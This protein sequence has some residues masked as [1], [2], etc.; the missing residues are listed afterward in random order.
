MV[1]VGGMYV[2]EG[3]RYDNVEQVDTRCIGR[4]REEKKGC[5]GGGGGGEEEGRGLKVAPERI[6]SPVE[7]KRGRERETERE[8][9]RDRAKRRK[10]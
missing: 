8:R 2:S 4:R 7:S 1:K 3:E 6:E 5:R 10:E 9:G